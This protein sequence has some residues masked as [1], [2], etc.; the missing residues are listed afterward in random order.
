MISE[1]HQAMLE[2]ERTFWTYDEP[3]ETRHPRA[4][5][6]LGRRLLCRA[7][8]AARAA[9]SDDPR[10]A[11]GPPPA[12]PAGAPSPR[13]AR[14]HRRAGRRTRMSD[15]SDGSGPV[16]RRTPRASDG[17]APVSGAV[18]IV[19]AV[20]AVVAGFFILRSISGDST[21]QP[22]DVRPT[23]DATQE[24]PTGD[25]ARG[26]DAAHVDAD[27]GAHHHGRR[28]AHR[29]RAPPSSSP[30]PTT[31]AA[32]AS[33]MSR[34]LEAGRLHDGRADRL[35]GPRPRPLD[36]VDRLLRPRT[37]RRPSRSPTRSAAALGGGVSVLPLPAGTPPVESGSLDGA[38]VLLMLGTDKAEQDAR[39]PQRR[40]HRQ[41]RC[42]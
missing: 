25:D 40:R 6:V 9:R 31:S 24:N 27:P 32:S 18:A 22:F 35:G 30:T 13:A 17:G 2:F 38:G 21:E 12:A 29:R 16:P 3:K 7:E 5:P 10:P 23:A 15:V 39:R 42:R 4:V 41:R 1:R 34:A 19:L 14:R 33:Q 36:G 20:I 37:G 28:H 11:G 26:D 8:R